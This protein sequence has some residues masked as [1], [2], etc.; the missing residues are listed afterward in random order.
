MVFG[1]DI[2]QSLCNACGIRQRKARRAMAAAAAAA[3]DTAFEKE[4]TP[5]LVIKT[6]K[7]NKLKTKTNQQ[8]DKT[9]DRGAVNVAKFKKRSCNL[10]IDAHEAQK[11]VC[12][13]DFLVTL[14]NKLAYDQVFPQ[15]EKD[16]A[17][18][19]MAMSLH[20]DAGR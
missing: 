1:Y 17:I 12:L 6:K 5:P 14:T 7:H 13:E 18:L 8:K 9:S 10:M 2:V 19:L 11:K 3:N 15:D 16:A 20:H 4:T